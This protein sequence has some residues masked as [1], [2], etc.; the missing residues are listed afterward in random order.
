MHSFNIV[1]ASLL[2]IFKTTKFPFPFSLI[3]NIELIKI[4]SENIQKF[5]KVY[6]NHTHFIIEIDVENSNYITLD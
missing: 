6:E 2:C 3:S 5:E 1:A 4:I